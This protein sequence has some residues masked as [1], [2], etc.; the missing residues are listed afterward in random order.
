MFYT[1]NKSRYD[2]LITQSYGDC[3]T[4]LECAWLLIRLIASYADEK[5]PKNEN[6]INIP[7][8]PPTALRKLLKLSNKSTVT[9]SV[10]VV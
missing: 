1:V 10:S 7:K 5:H 8:L 9:T 4:L 3:C 6:P 2:I